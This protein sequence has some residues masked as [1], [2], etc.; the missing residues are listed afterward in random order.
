MK[1]HING[2]SYN[3]RHQKTPKVGIKNN[4]H[5]KCA[6]AAVNLACNI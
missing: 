5:R 6:I 2:K 3:L 4:T 1:M